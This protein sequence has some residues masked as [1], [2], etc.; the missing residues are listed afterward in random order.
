MKNRRE[1]KKRKQLTSGGGWWGKKDDNL[2]RG[3]LAKKDK[4]KRE[5]VC[6]LVKE[7]SRKWCW[8]AGDE[9][10]SEQEAEK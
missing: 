8:K 4:E 3:E 1:N 7:I 9:C 5:N 2:R 10:T 6:V